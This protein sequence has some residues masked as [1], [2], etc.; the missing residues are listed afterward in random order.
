[1]TPQEIKSQ[2]TMGKDLDSWKDTEPKARIAAFVD[3]IC[4]EQS[5]DFLPPSQRIAVFDNDGTLWSEQPFYFQGLFLFDRVREL[6]AEHP[7]WH[8]TQPF[9]SVLE[10]DWHT[11]GQLGVKALLE[12]AMA[13]H[14]GMTT[15]EFEHIAKGWLAK[16]RHPQLGRPFTKLIFQPMIELLNYLRAHEF[17]TFIVSGGGIEF[18]RTFSEYA[19]GIPPEQ[20][21]GSSIVTEYEVRDGGPVLVRLP[22]LNFLDDNAGKPV[23]INQHIGRR[24][25][26]AFGNSDGDLQMFEWV[27][28]GEGPRLCCLLHHDDADREFAYDRESAAGRLDKAL[29]EAAQRGITVVSMK[30]DWKRV[31]ID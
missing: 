3:S 12:L 13:T 9:K 23:G 20:V 10:R 24:P 25:V 14:G 28:A 4:D 19:Y 27:M 30:R 11:L 8:E 18:V 5:P 1:M 22:K 7:E 16:A 6:V 21:V 31:Y 26:A 2:D 17:K 29:S 15:T